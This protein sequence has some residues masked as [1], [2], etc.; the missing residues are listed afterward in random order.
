MPTLLTLLVF[1]L[2]APAAWGQDAPLPRREFRAVWVATVNNIDWPSRKDLPTEE[3]QAELRQIVEQAAVLRLNAIVFQVRP[4]GCAFY[5]SDLEPWSEWLTGEQGKAP[6]PAWDPLE[7]L[8]EA[9]HPRGI[10]VHAW[11]NPYRARHPSAESPEA[12]DHIL[13]R[14]PSACVPYGKYR[15]MDPGDPRTANWSLR[16]MA[17]LVRRYD[18]D[19]IHLDDYFYPYPEKGRPF[20][21]DQSYQRYRRSGGTRPRAAWRR[22]NIDEFVR[23]LY[24]QTHEI[25]SWVKVGISPF[26]IARP[27]LPKGI[28]AGIDQYHDLSADVL[29]WLRDGLCDYLA[30]QLYWPIDQK[31]QS[32]AVL[33]PWWCAQPRQQRHVWPGISASRAAAG[34][35]PWR[36]TELPQQIRMIRAQNP[37]DSGHIHFSFRALQ[38][39]GN[40]LAGQLLRQSYQQAAPVPACPWLPAQAAGKPEVALH[41]RQGELQIRVRCS[42]T[43]RF[44]CVQALVNR[45]WQTH[46]V[47][48]RDTALVVMPAGTSR[49]TVRE[50]AN[51]GLAGPAVTLAVAP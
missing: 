34:K 6:E 21:D 41:Q 25:K 48:G 19:G 47:R 23:R 42:P 24:E 31:A 1:L 30:P 9:A 51:N 8:I 3:A 28:V 13:R 43:A 46:A 32:F 14:E 15:W 33:L 17:D 50:L 40:G 18:L 45:R 35:R 26:G 16:V 2:A 5:R 12:A 38:A 37:T 44:Y 22:A 27:G 39:N 20:P 36:R 10:E 4:S 11:C 7:F 29:G 49:V